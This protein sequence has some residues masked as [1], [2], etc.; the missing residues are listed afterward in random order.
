MQDDGRRGGCRVREK[1]AGRAL[2]T[3]LALLSALLLLPPLCRAV[4][5]PATGAAAA[6]DDETQPLMLSP[7]IRQGRLA[8]AR[9]RSR[10]VE[11]HSGEPMGEAGFL[12]TDEATAKHMF[13]WFFEAQSG[14]PDAPLVVWLQGGPGGSSMF[15]LFSEMGP[16]ALTA[17][18]EPVRRNTTWNRDYAMLFIDNPVGAGFSFTEQPDGYC[19]ESKGCVASNLCEPSCPP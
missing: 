6:P 8:E 15:G 7:L 2:K 14:D 16:Y 18:L 11:P 13:Y 10:V 5:S 9:A 3:M 12:T 19:T 4:P 1:K 17:Q